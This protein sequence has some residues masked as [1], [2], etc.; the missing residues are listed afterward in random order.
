A[1]ADLADV[2][3]HHVEIVEQ[4]VARGADVD[5]AVGGRGEPLVGV[6]DQVA[7]LV[8]PD[9]QARPVARG[10]GCPPLRPGQRA[11]PP[12]E[13][14]RPGRPR[15]LPEDLLRQATRRLQI[16]ALVAAAL[17]FLGP[18]L[19]HLALHFATPR[20]PG[21]DGFRI[22]DGVASFAFLTSIGL[23]CYL[24]VTRRSPD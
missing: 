6:L 19:G 15:R 22:I 5:L 11:C 14:P 17:W 20:V 1:V 13:L 21:A 16:L 8:Q 9:E 23:F 4:P 3:L 12:R 10:P 18:T 2:L 24:R 7:S